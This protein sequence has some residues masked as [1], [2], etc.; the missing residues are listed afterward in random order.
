MKISNYLFGLLP[1][2]IS[3]AG[4]G[5]GESTATK[6]DETNP[7]ATESVFDP[8]VGTIDTAKAVEELSTNRTDDLNKEIEK[9]Q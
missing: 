5:G 7:A 4:C 2:L 9:S 1:V 6:Q 8:M 3:L